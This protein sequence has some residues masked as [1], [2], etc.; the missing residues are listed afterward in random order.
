MAKE[1]DHATNFG[2]IEMKRGMHKTTAGNG[3]KP[4]I[5]FQHSDNMSPNQF[6]SNTPIRTIDL[7]ESYIIVL[8]NVR[9]SEPFSVGNI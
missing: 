3:P 8:V 5:T 2:M 7:S 9:Q 6:S 4:N 1:K